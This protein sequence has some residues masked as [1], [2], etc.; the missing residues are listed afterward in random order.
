[1]QRYCAATRCST[2]ARQSASTHSCGFLSRSFSHPSRIF[3][4]MDY[5]LP[6]RVRI[7][8][9]FRATIGGVPHRYET[10]TSSELIFVSEDTNR[11]NVIPHHEYWERHSKGEIKERSEEH[12]S[13]LQS[14]MRISYAVFCLKKKN[15]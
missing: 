14:I 12:T 15:K 8:A 13:E 2:I 1:M 4:L 10:T 7:P 3:L 9:G 11:A 6:F 5:Q